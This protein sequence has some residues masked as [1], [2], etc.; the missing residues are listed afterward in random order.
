[1]TVVV[2]SANSGKGIRG[3]YS[4]DWRIDTESGILGAIDRSIDLYEKLIEKGANLGCDIIAFPE[5][6]LGLNSWTVAHADMLP[7]ILPEANS[8]IEKRL[9]GAAASH[10]M[11]LI[12]ASR[13]VRTRRYRCRGVSHTR[14]GES[15]V[16]CRAVERLGRRSG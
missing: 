1:M 16:S 15:D 7:A 9:A 6:M 4:I 10:R 13:G 3:D 11:Y 5:D 14:R 8:R 2:G 12:C